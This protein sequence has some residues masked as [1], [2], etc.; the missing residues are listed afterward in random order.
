MS[1]KE[2]HKEIETFE[3]PASETSNQTE[4]VEKTSTEATETEG[5]Y[6]KRNFKNCSKKYDSR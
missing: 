5:Y 1:E 2:S 6:W 3:T 4:T